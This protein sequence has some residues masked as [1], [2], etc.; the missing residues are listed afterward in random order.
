MG[1][2]VARGRP[3]IRVRFEP[4]RL[5]AEHLRIAYELV[6]PVRRVRVREPAS[7]IEESRRPAER[8]G[9]RAS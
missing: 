8:R 5:S 3:V 7:V 9:S 2:G 6:V 1:R 4:A